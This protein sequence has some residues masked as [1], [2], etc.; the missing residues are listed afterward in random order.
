M[1]GG[2]EA[3]H[4]R[5]IIETYGCVEEELVTVKGEAGWYQ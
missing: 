4:I 2:G 5:V 1:V 3:D